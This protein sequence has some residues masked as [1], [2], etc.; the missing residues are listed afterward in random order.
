MPVAWLCLSSSAHEE[1]KTAYHQSRTQPPRG[2]MLME[3]RCVRRSRGDHQVCRRTGYG[4]RRLERAGGFR[5]QPGTGESQGPGKPGNAGGGNRDPGGCARR[6]RRGLHCGQRE[7]GIGD[8]DADGAAVDWEPV[9][10]SRISQRELVC[11][12]RKR[13]SRRIEGDDRTRAAARSC[14]PDGG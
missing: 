6:N 12:D 1:Q 9:R 13:R 10:I 2:R 5:G 4:G 3:R 8:G 14:S 11:S 7:V